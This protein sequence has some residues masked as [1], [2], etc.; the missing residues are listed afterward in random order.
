MGLTEHPLADGRTVVVAINY[1]PTPVAC[2]VKVNG[3]LGRV[4]RGEVRADKIVLPPNEAALF[5]VK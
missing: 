3:T 4:W 1:D 2:P 5:E